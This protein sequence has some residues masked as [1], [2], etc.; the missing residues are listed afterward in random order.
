MAQKDDNE[1]GLMKRAAGV[2]LEI[3]SKVFKEN[4]KDIIDADRVSQLVQACFCFTK[5][6]GRDEEHLRG[7]SSFGNFSEISLSVLLRSWQGTFASPLQKFLFI[8]KDR[9][10]KVTGGWRW[11]SP[12]LLLP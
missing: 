4:I 7:R 8:D 11:R 9:G 1:L 12:L 10:F 3:Y 2:T 5:V 6:A